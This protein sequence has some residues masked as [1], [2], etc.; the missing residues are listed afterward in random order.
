MRAGIEVAEMQENARFAMVKRHHAE[1][2]AKALAEGKMDLQMVPLCRFV[3]KTKKFFTSS[4]CSGRIVLLE[5]PENGK[6]CETDFHRKWHGKVS[7]RELWDG[8]VEPTAGE[9]WFKLDGFILHIGTDSLENARTIL[10][11]MK[12]AGVKRGGIIV[13]K[14]GKFL[15]EMQGTESMSF[16][17]KSENEIIVE[18]AFM[19]RILAKANKKLAKNY[20]KLKAFEKACRKNLE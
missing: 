17:V 6:K 7:F 13:A 4:C 9:L 16:P 1:T 14:Q 2:F 18:K 12:L 8:I 20:A 3:A 5:M 19:K 11:V 15:V 10:A